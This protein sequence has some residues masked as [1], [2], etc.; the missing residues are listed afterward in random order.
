MKDIQ[1]SDPDIQCLKGFGEDVVSRSLDCP[2]H[3][4]VP[5]APL[6][7]NIYRMQ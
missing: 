3:H 5:G 1:E 6:P 2:G 4:V 7:S